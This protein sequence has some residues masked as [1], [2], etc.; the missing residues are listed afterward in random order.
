MIY[1]ISGSHSTGDLAAAEAAGA[2]INVLRGT[3][4]DGL[5]ALNVGLPHTVG[6]TVGVAHLDTESNA[7]FAE[8]ALCHSCC[9]SSGKTT[10]P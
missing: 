5:D 3:V 1:A 8:F 2:H 6:A 10:V 9:T 4:D 7:L